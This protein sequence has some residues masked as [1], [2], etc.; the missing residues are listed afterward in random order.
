MR[1]KRRDRG[2]D[3]LAVWTVEDGERRLDRAWCPGGLED[4]ERREPRGGWSLA[5]RDQ[6]GER[7]LRARADDVEAGDR[8]FAHDHAIRREV[9]YERGNFL[10]ERG[11][12]R[13]AV[14]ILGQM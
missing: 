11:A 1:T 6:R 9:G 5:I 13:Q 10:R 4:A 12:D 2:H 14:A 3:D 8:R 7:R